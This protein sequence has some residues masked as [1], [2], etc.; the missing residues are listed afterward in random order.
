MQ[1][2]YAIEDTIYTDQVEMKVLVPLENKELFAQ[3]ITALSEGRNMKG[4]GIITIYPQPR[5]KRK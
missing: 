1:D 5:R 2:G 4:S 3:R